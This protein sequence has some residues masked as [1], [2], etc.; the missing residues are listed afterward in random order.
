MSSPTEA[1]SPAAITMEAFFTRQRANE[2]VELP[3]DLPDGTPTAHRIRVRGVDSDAFQAAEAESKRRLSELV[4]SRKLSAPGAGDFAAERIILLSALVIGWTFDAPCTPE[5][6]QGL[7]RE[8]PQLA[9]QIDRIAARRSLFFVKS[10]AS[11]TASQ[12]SSSS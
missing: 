1:L 2:G 7:L 12:Q 4:I 6:V 10:S 3:L 8:A 5:N 11:S 9:D